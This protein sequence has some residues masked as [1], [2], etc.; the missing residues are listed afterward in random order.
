[1]NVRTVT[2]LI[3]L[4]T[5]SLTLSVLVGCG[6]QRV[7]SGFKLQGERTN[8]PELMIEEA[9]RASLNVAQ[10]EREVEIPQGAFIPALDRY[11][12]RARHHGNLHAKEFARNMAKLNAY[13]SRPYANY[14]ELLNNPAHPLY[15]PYNNALA[16]T[17]YDL[18]WSMY[19]LADLTD[20]ASWS[21]RADS[22]VSFYRDR[23]VLPTKGNIPGYWIF[24]DGLLEHYKRTKSSRSKEAIKMIVEN[25]A[26][27][28]DNTQKHETV[29][30]EQSREVAYVIMAYLA[31]ESVGEPRHARLNFLIDQALD[32]TE[33]WMDG[34]A[35]YVR[36]FM[37]GLTAK[38]LIRYYEHPLGEQDEDRKA[39]IVNKLTKMADWLWD[40]TWVEGSGAFRYT[41]RMVE[42]NA[43]LNPS[44]DL[45]LLVAPIFEWVYS[46]TK[47][48]QFRDRADRIFEGG[49]RQSYLAG[50]KQ[51]NQYMFW[52]YSHFVKPRL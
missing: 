10:L 44:P 7:P 34:R 36:P 21:L 6:G 4:L 1:M 37:V 38:A 24:T 50:A 28:R 33:Q 3:Y 18:G 9:P 19:Q 29:S 39:L 8:P 32:H 2:N 26:F 16:A 47:K 12:T 20:D 51:Y 13:F 42:G 23:Y 15:Q 5:T 43:D 11:E 41:D 52:S 14:D 30:F 46:K 22:A 35:G 17:Y 48:P 31:A 45:S 25:A 27:A 40:Y 49:V